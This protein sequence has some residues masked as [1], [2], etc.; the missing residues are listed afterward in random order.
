M[1]KRFKMLINLREYLKVI[2]VEESKI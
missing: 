1:C 2:V